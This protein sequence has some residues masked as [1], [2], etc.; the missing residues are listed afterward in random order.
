ME[1]TRRIQWVSTVVDGG[2]QFGTGFLYVRPLLCELL[3]HLSVLVEILLAKDADEI[4]S[5]LLGR[6]LVGGQFFGIY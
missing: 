6:H 5:G 3:L 1:S 4:P 2:S